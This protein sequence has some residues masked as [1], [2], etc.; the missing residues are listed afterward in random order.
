MPTPTNTATLAKQKTVSDVPLF[1][2]D[3]TD[4]AMT[5]KAISLALDSLVAA[6]GALERAIKSAV[7]SK[8]R[9]TRVTA[10]T[11]LKILE[12]E[13]R[14]A[15]ALEIASD[16]A[17]SQAIKEAK[18]LL[19]SSR[20][21][22][23]SLIDEEEFCDLNDPAPPQVPDE[24][25]KPTAKTPPEPTSTDK[26]DDAATAKPSEEKAKS[27]V[28]PKEEAQQ[29]LRTSSGQGKFRFKLEVERVCALTSQAKEQEDR[30]NSAAAAPL[31]GMAPESWEEI[32]RAQDAVHLV[33]D[34]KVRNM[35]AKSGGD[36]GTWLGE[37]GIHVW[38]FLRNHYK[39]FIDETVDFDP[40]HI[41][42]SRPGLPGTQTGARKK[43]NIRT[44][45][46]GTAQNL[47]STTQGGERSEGEGGLN[48][49]V[50]KGIETVL[51]GL[52][53]P[54]ANEM[55][56]GG[57]DPLK[58]LILQVLRETNLLPDQRQGTADPGLQS[59]VPREN[60]LNLQQ[61]LE[62]EDSMREQFGP[63]QWSNML[64]YPWDMQNIPKDP[65]IVPPDSN[66]FVMP[67]P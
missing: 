38:T 30:L 60:P 55:T 20:I 3:L 67:E 6:R 41:P 36:T 32:S 48:S 4:S 66:P 23:D 59:Q 25:P 22:I 28:S 39:A 10:K 21:T 49:Q 56:A 14:K 5:A 62:V 26:K 8:R 35:A 15:S 44:S 7:E 52:R 57:T 50:R 13:V 31:D 64:H 58:D 11:C 51:G 12:E 61:E 53:D 33:Y 34:N 18:N 46:L 43:T 16:C 40:C 65:S 54:S 37:K 42:L 63:N 24:P 47:T 9:A 19:D 27:S 17:L 2:P 29:I 1:S 45:G